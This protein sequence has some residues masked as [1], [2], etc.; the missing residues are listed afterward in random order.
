MCWWHHHIHRVN[1]HL[2]KTPPLSLSILIFNSSIHPQT[3]RWPAR[4]FCRWGAQLW[5]HS[6]ES[7]AD[8]CVQKTRSPSAGYWRP[9]LSG[10][11]GFPSQWRERSATP[12]EASLLLP[13]RS[14][15]WKQTP[16]RKQRHR[17]W[18]GLEWRSRSWETGLKV[19]ATITPTCGGRMYW[20]VL[21]Y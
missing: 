13:D 18:Y 7:G 4:C 11:L 12:S 2:L 8:S 1:L 21:V 14:W 15:W 6:S 5:P 10:S 19:D 16:D 20:F 3:Q 9:K 17:G